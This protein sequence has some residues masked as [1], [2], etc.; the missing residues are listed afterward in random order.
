M[1]D[2]LANLFIVGAAKCGTT[3]LYEYLSQHPQ[4]YMSP[5]KEPH[6]FSDKV[7]N[8]DKELYKKPVKGEKYH[9]KVIKDIDVYTSLFDGG[10][11]FKIR[12]EASPSYLWDT[13]AAAK[14]YKY[15]PNS[16]IIAILRNPIDRLVSSYQMDHSAGKQN[17]TDFLTTVKNEYKKEKKIWGYDRIYLDLGFYYKQLSVYAGLFPASQILVL[18]FD[19]LVKRPLETLLKVLQFLE[20]DEKYLAGIDVGKV[21]NESASIKYP[22]L[23]KLKKAKLLKSVIRVAAKRLKFLKKFTHK[24]GYSLNLVIDDEAR[25]YLDNMYHDDLAKLKEVYNIEF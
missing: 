4:V 16:K 14:I 8:E 21:H 15:N 19:D 24:K 2:N 9:T 17:E 13:D 5:V 25:T 6:F 18:K 11:D 12:G 7:E 1:K 23:K 20:I 22:F 3:S 10:S